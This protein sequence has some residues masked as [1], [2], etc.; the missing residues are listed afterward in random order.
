MRYISLFSGVEAASLAWESLGWEPVAFAEIE[1]FP[2]AV[3]A[4]RWPDVPNLGDVTKVDWSKYRGTVDV[5]VGGF[6]C[7]SY[8]LA[9]LRQGLDDPRGE[10]MLEF[11]R[12]CRDVD[13]DW[14]VGENVAGL[15][16]ANGGGDFKTFLE[17]VAF[18]WPR[19]GVSWRVLNAKGFGVPQLRRRVFIV[20]NTRDWRRSAKVL[21][22]PE[23]VLWNFEK[24]AKEGEA[25]AER[26]GNGVR[27]KGVSYGINRNAF[28]ENGTSMCETGLFETSPCLDTHSPNHSVAYGI[29]LANTTGNGIGVRKDAMP[30]VTTRGPDAAAYLLRVR[31]GKDGGRKGA[32]FQEERSGTLATSN[33]QTLFV[34]DSDG[35]CIRHLTPRECERLQGMPDDHTKIPWKGKPAD[36]CPDGPRYKAIGNS[37]AV[38]VMR[39]IGE[40]VQEVDALLSSEGDADGRGDR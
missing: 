40:R 4:H 27:A 21:L 14:I 13:P 28:F 30:T 17:A 8:S 3:L 39:W 9:G 11:L 15:L 18:L 25:S 37:M 24:D 12:A 36:E 34:T 31:G 22:E 16:S 23:S 26:A 10:L 33:D 20:I 6:P 32:L 38:P 7:Q 35:W 2:S 29:R 19:G 1:P 5:V